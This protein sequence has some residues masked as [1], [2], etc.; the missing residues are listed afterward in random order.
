MNLISYQ[1]LLSQLKESEIYN[2]WIKEN[3]DSFLSHF[4]CQLD[5]EFNPKSEWEIGIY[6]NNKITVFVPIKQGFELKPA[7]E[8]FKKPNSEVEPLKVDDIKLDLDQALNIFK[9]NFPKFFAKEVLSDGFLI[10]QTYNDKTV[11]NFTFI[12]KQIRFINLKVDA[13]SG[14]IVSHDTV[15][16]VQQGHANK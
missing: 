7:D 16:L 13:G 10:L 1:E 9:E 6:S 14:E 11:W 5:S 15:N 12:T 8:I 4:F 2:D 3:S